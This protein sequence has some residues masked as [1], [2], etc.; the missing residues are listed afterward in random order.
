M[1][2]IYNLKHFRLLIAVPIILLLISLYF[3]PKI[4][5]DSSLRGGITITIHTANSVSISG[6]S[7]LIDS[8]IPGAASEVSTAPGGISII[9]AANQSLS[10]AENY[11][12]NCY[13]A[14]SNYTTAQVI[15]TS[16]NASLSAEPSNK[17]LA[18]ML[19]A[20]YANE[21]KAAQ[22]LKE[23]A[24]LMLES[25]GMVTPINSSLISSISN[26][27]PSAVISLLNNESA[28]ANNAYKD[29]VIS[30]LQS[31]VPFSTYSY[32]T[33]TP[34]LGKYFLSELQ[35]IVIISFVLVAIAVFF[36][37]RS[38]VPSLIVVFGAANDII[39]ALGAMGI[40]GI[41]LGV[42]SI[43][44]LL[45][46]IGYSI[47]TDI[48]SSIRI[49]KRSEETAQVRA[50]QSMKTGL[51]MNSTAIIVFVILFFVSYVYFIQ[52]YY[53][54]AGVVLAGLIGDIIAT[55]LGNTP[56]ILWY[57]ERK[58]RR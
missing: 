4:P 54:I 12:L 10:N 39:I 45:M 38:I 14:Y 22:T 8:K 32:E 36:I 58:D 18:A 57:K 17:T 13:A 25:I 26:A 50:F 6:L 48:L 51:T 49:L 28:K 5:L 29:K 23:N 55:W 21:T 56:I 46:L 30:A 43:G 33:V 15:V 27:T 37:F 1:L 40:F 44:G 52:T 35:L 34:T 42:A 19:S 7:A 24:Q 53:E 9:I 16:L 11:L 20:A 41:P 3:I 31:I 2:N 47:D